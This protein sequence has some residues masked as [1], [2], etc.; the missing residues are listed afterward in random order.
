MPVNQYYLKARLL[1]TALTAV[2]AVL[3]FN[4]FIAPLYSGNLKDLYAD[5]PML[6][7]GAFSAGIVFV[8]VQLNRLV[9]KELF[10]RFHFREELKMPTT[11]HLMWSDPFFDRSTKGKIRDRIA[12]D[13]EITLLNETEEEADDERARKLIVSAVARIRTS[14]KENAMLLQHN[15]EYGFFRNL[16]GG[17]LIAV[18]FSL[19]ILGFGWINGETRAMQIGGVSSG[20]YLVPIILSRFIIRIYGKYYSKILYEQFLGQKTSNP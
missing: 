6:A 8:F 10:Q 9:A 15:I 7:N 11:E 3:F 1:P 13:Y 5:L 17:C 2:P 12:R 20:I 16:L 19:L 4:Y 18:T 14:L